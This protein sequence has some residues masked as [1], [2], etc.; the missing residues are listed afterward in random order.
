MH[1]LNEAEIWHER[2]RELLREAE[3]NR[4]AQRLKAGRPKQ[5][6]FTG[7]MRRRAA[8]LLS[9]MGLAVLLA[10]SAAY[11]LDI[12]C[13]PGSNVAGKECLGTDASDTMDGTEGNDDIRGLGGNDVVRGLGGVDAL[14]GDDQ[15][16]SPSG[17]GDDEVFGGT[18]GDDLIGLDG[19]DLLSGGRGADSIDALEASSNGGVDTVKGGGGNDEVFADDGQRDMIDCGRGTRDD[20]RHDSGLDTLK[21]C[22]IKDAL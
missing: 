11:A 19:S 9:I 15:E 8:L 1:H 20:V 13:L 22:E 5:K 17:Q 4:L 21:N 14:E 16:M 12:E 2:S 10:A 7:G 6:S 18:G 3:Y